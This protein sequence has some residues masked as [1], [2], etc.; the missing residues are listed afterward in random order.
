[1]TPES[2]PQDRFGGAPPGVRRWALPSVIVAALVI[3]IAFVMRA[4]PTV[5]YEE[6]TESG[7]VRVVE[8]PDGL[9]ELYLED[10]GSRQTALY[11]LFPRRLVLAYTRVAA[12]G[13]ALVPPEARVLYVG[14]GGGA[15]PS[16]LRQHRNRTPID[17]VEIEPAVVEAAREHFGFREDA[18]MRAWIADARPFIEDAP[19]GFWGLI[20]LDAFSEDGVPTHLTTVEF[21]EA[22]RHA[23]TP[24]GIV[25]GNVH[26][27]GA[28]HEVVVAGY[29]EVFDHVVL[30]DVPD[31]AQQIV[32]AGG[33]RR[34]LER[35]SV[36]TAV[37]AFAA[38]TELDFDLAALVDEAWVGPAPAQGAAPRRD[39]AESGASGGGP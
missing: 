13:P 16:W 28:E 3:A 25:V 31:H 8:R 2:S 21:L 19:A 10:G 23:L 24:E 15:M 26:L 33:S 11:P 37:R 22:V 32:V 7:V 5:L 34:S 35:D 27:G 1:M 17:I 39:G 18:A 36:M 9:R 14:L 20:V 12:V 6:S 38:E 4:E 29:R 30:L